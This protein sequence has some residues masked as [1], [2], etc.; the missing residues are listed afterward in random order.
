MANDLSLIDTIA[1]NIKTEI[2]VLDTQYVT[3]LYDTTISLVRGKYGF[4]VIPIEF[5]TREFTDVSSLPNIRLDLFCYYTMKSDEVRDQQW[6]VF[7]GVLNTIRNTFLTK[8]KIPSPLA[9]VKID[10]NFHDDLLDIKA[11]TRAINS[12]MSFIYQKY[13][14]NT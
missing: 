14:L 2:G 12:V 10:V 5:I 7:L 4:N 11:G 1:Q 6:S 3:K 8:A 9:T 13:A